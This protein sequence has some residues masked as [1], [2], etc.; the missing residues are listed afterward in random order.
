ML[1]QILLQGF[2]TLVDPFIISLCNGSKAKEIGVKAGITAGSC[3]ISAVLFG[4]TELG[5]KI[6]Y[7]LSSV[8]CGSII[9]DYVGLVLTKTKDWI[10][11]KLDDYG[12]D[13]Y[14]DIIDPIIDIGTGIALRKTAGWS[15]SLPTITPTTAKDAQTL[16]LQGN[17]NVSSVADTSSK[18]LFGKIFNGL[19]NAASAIF[20]L[21]QSTQYNEGHL[22]SNS[23]DLAGGNLLLNGVVK[24]TTNIGSSIWNFFSGTNKAALSVYDIKEILRTQISS[25]DYNR[26]TVKAQAEQIFVEIQKSAQYIERFKDK[27]EIQK[28][29]EILTGLYI[30]DSGMELKSAYSSALSDNPKLL[31]KSGILVDKLMEAQV[32]NRLLNARECFSK[33]AQFKE[34]GIEM[35]IEMKPYIEQAAKYKLIEETKIFKGITDDEA[36]AYK[37]LFSRAAEIEVEFAQVSSYILAMQQQGAEESPEFA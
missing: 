12:Y 25:E 4:P 16:D 21:G 31:D 35:P 1:N 28:N 8:V 37:S 13:K 30:K 7:A 26:A 3:A 36:I 33:I 6:F 14:I 2:N 10:A 15:I 27:P 17:T 19:S 29:I 32:T 23:L 24:L 20:N 5:A 11:D 34:Y 22:I 9:M 18:G